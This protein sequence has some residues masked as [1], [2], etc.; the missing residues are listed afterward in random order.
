MF[1]SENFCPTGSSRVKALH[2]LLLLLLLVSCPADA[3]RSVLRLGSA[4]LAHLWSAAR[5]MRA[6]FYSFTPNLTRLKRCSG[7]QLSTV[8]HSTVH[9]AQYSYSYSYFTVAE[10]LQF[11]RF[12]SCNRFFLFTAQVAQIW[13]LTAWTNLCSSN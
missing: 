10:G 8:L 1:T 2:L 3:L 11:S 4:R 9:C 13:P 7:R 5:R 12:S 6:Q